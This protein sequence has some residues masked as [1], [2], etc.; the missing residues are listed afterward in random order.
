MICSMLVLNNQLCVGKIC[1]PGFGC[2]LLLTL[3]ACHMSGQQ[4]LKLD[5]CFYF[6]K[7][8]DIQQKSKRDPGKYARQQIISFYKNQTMRRQNHIRVWRRIVNAPV[9][10]RATH[11][12]PGFLEFYK[13]FS[14]C[15]HI[16]GEMRSLMRKYAFLSQLFIVIMVAI[17]RHGRSDFLAKMSID[18]WRQYLR[19]IRLP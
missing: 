13:L 10:D 3:A 9:I 15:L 19:Q 1:P 8:A 2:C 11:R 5:F 12:I 6:N 4:S 14:K 7:Y 18:N 17:H 16:K